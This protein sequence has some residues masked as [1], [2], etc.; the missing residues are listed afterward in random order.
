MTSLCTRT[1]I[2]N[3]DAEV[4]AFGRPVTINIMHQ[5]NVFVM[6]ETE[7]NTHGGNGSIKGGEK[8]VVPRGKVV[9][10]EVGIKDSRFTLAP[11]HDLNGEL[12]CLVVIFA[13]EKLNPCWVL[14]VDI[15]Y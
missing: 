7:D 12:R 5:D 6:D 10:E 14:G 2:E 15:I 4:H 9:M 1:A 8:K 3:V 11:F 13:A